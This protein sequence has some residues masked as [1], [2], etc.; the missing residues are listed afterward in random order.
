MLFIC[1]SFLTLTSCLSA[2]HTIPS[3]RVTA[4][5]SQSHITIIIIITVELEG[6]DLSVADTMEESK[7]RMG[8]IRVP[9]SRHGI[10]YDAIARKIRH[11]GGC[12]KSRGRTKQTIV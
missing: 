5:I 11:L 9:Q 2:P 1:L 8:A 4:S 6:G 10:S 7:W 12:N 3:H